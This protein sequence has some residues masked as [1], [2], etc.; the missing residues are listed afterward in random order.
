[1]QSLF[2]PLNYNKAYSK[3]RGN[4]IILKLL[5]TIKMKSCYIMKKT[6]I[7][8]VSLICLSF[9][10]LIAAPVSAANTLN[11]SN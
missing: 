2:T 5:F 10:I 7:L 9:N 4:R 11:F 3:K 8:L 1:M 6:T